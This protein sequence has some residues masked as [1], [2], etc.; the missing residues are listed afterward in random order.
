MFIFKMI[1]NAEK[2]VIY[3]GTEEDN[4]QK[5]KIITNLYNFIGVK[6]AQYLKSTITY[7]YIIYFHIYIIT[8]NK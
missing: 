4:L 7:N 5:K 6:I 1:K 8:N 2:H 3:L